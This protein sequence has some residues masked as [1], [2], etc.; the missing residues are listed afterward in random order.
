MCLTT[1]RHP[2]GAFSFCF[3]G[4]FW[5]KLDSSTVLYVVLQCGTANFEKTKICYGVRGYV[6]IVNQCRTGFL[7]NVD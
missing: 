4:F 2:F 6:T 1:C 7:R 3:Y 5:F